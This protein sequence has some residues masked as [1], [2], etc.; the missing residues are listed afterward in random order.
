MC[1][2]ATRFNQLGCVKFLNEAGGGHF[3]HL[4]C[5]FLFSDTDFLNMVN[6]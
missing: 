4:L 3:E 2:F 5:F 1:E 6:S